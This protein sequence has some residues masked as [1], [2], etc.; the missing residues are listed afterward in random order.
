MRT[1]QLQERHGKYWNEKRQTTW[2]PASAWCP[3]DAPLRYADDLSCFVERLL[4][5]RTRITAGVP[6]I[7][8][9]CCPVVRSK[10][11]RGTCDRTA[12]G[13]EDRNLEI[14]N[15]WEIWRVRRPED[16]IKTTESRSANAPEVGGVW[17]PDRLRQPDYLPP[18]SVPQDEG[19]RLSA[20]RPYLTAGLPLSVQSNTEKN[21]L[22]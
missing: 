22:A 5:L 12:F 9:A 21:K 11:Y 3:L 16:T 8:V 17:L 2:N 19:R 18:G 15:G 10:Q 6:F 4:L 14:R 7:G 1:V 13:Q 20:L